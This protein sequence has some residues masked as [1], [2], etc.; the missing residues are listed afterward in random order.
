MRLI[1][2]PKICKAPND[3]VAISKGFNREVAGHNKP[4]KVI[5]GWKRIRM[6]G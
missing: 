4:G 5:K 6:V 3:S 2:L 1:K